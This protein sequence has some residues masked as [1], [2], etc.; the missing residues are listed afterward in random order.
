CAVADTPVVA[1]LA[2][3][4]TPD[5]S[6]SDWSTPP[7]RALQLLWRDRAGRVALG[8][9]ALLAGGALLAPWLAP[10]DPARV[11]DAVALRAVP[12]SA[13]HWF[14]TDETSR[15]VFSRML[16]GARISLAVAALSALWSSLVG[17]VYGGIAGF[18]GGRLEGAMMRFVDAMLAIPRIL[19]VMTILSLWGEI[20]ASTLVA[21]L[22]GTGWFSVARLAR[23]EAAALRHRDF[24]VAVQALGAEPARV[25]VRHVLPHAA[26][27]VLVAATIAVGQVVV[28][29]AGLSFLGYGVR[30]PTPT[31]GNIISD[32]RST[33][34][35]TWWL[36]FFPGLALIGTALAVN[37]VA[38][39]LRAAL[40]PRQLPAP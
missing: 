11:L 15:D 14:G 1:S 24:V 26:G 35:T 34:A 32:G 29:E 28:L 4:A 31:W 9:L 3:P 18:V 27:P 21:V 6:A 19:L 16:Y 40:N 36:T 13:A 23:A 5:T 33:I 2:I 7:R 8:F 12:P 25:F 39:R 17:L 37:T 10:Y 38:D 30:P 20:D 22:G